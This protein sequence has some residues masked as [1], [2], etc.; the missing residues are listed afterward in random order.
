M[1]KIIC[2]LTLITGLFIVPETVLSQQRGGGRQS[3]NFE[4]VEAEKIAFIT[5]ELNLTSKEA[6]KFFPVY[7][8]Y[9]D[10]VNKV[11]HPNTTTS[12]NVNPN[13]RKMDELSRETEV[14]ELKK[15]YRKEFTDILGAS[16]ASRFFEVE[17]E[18]REKLINELRRRGGGQFPNHPSY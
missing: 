3:N 5:K 7:N 18:F 10:A 8:A 14:L 12:R 17:R 2:L 9:R 13:S 16:R 15:K 4:R 11:I 1:K 6:Q